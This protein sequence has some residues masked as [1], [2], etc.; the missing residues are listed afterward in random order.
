[1]KPEKERYNW[2]RQAGLLSTIPFLMAVPPIAGLLI[3]RY[4]DKKFNLQPLFTIV[5]LLLGFAAGVREVAL[6]IKKANA[7][8]DG[9]DKRDRST[10]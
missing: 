2:A 3:G 1:M 8:S 7:P 9:D 6:V 4:L 10:K 5:L